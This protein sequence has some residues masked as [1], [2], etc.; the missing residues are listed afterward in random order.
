MIIFIHFNYFKLLDITTTFTPPLSTTKDEK[1]YLHAA[2]HRHEIL[3]K[4]KT[5]GLKGGQRDFRNSLF[6]LAQQNNTYYV[7]HVIPTKTE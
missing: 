1:T 3:T 7:I 6:Q 2:T 4:N 5:F